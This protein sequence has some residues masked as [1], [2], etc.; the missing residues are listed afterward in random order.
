MNSGGQP[1]R[2]SIVMPSYNQAAFLEEAVMSV[3]EQDYPNL[4]VIVLDGG[5]TDGSLAILEKYAARFAYWHSRPDRGQIDA[6][7][8]GFGLATGDLLGWVNSDDVLLPGALWALAVAHARVPEAGLIGGNYIL[9]DQAGMVT[10]VKR[11]PAQAAF[12][13]RFGV[14]AV[15]QPGSVVTR[16][17]Y[18]RVGGFDPRFDYVMDTD[19]YFRILASGH[20][21]VHIDRWLSAFRI[22]SR[23]KT[24]AQRDRAKAEGR[25]ARASWFSETRAY[26]AK[27]G[28][29][30][31][32]YKLWQVGNGNYARAV[33]ASMR[34][35]GTSWKAWAVANCPDSPEARF[36]TRGPVQGTDPSGERPQ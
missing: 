24:V 3:L 34:G 14:M 18:S 26:E 13:A 29:T 12:F 9:I 32:A 27:R 2:I 1:A 11:H 16:A 8:Q 4:E 7:I 23:A 15:N 21:Y 25:Q 31:V 6:L 30:R 17:A 33:V 20:S 35:R 19:L 28:L 10:R 36:V 5:S 22:H